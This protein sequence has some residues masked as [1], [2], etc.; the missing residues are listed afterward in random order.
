MQKALERIIAV[1]FSRAFH[2]VQMPGY[3]TAIGGTGG[4]MYAEL[5]D[6]R[7]CVPSLLFARS[8]VES[9]IAAEAQSN[10]QK[11]LDVDDRE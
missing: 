1:L 6:E 10:P 5:G 9:Q 3:A 11:C 2:A 8:S 4:R 7:Q